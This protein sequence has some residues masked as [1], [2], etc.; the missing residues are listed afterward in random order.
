[1]WALGAPG[2]TLRWQSTETAQAWREM[3]PVHAR[4]TELLPE[5]AGIATGHRVLDVAAGTG[6]QTA[7][8]ARRVSPTGRVVAIDVS[9]SMLAGARATL[10]ERSLGNV[11]LPV[12]DA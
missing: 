7:A 5:Q 9:A 3:K 6:E 12:M 8:A 4:A 11:E 10:D 1:V 2:A